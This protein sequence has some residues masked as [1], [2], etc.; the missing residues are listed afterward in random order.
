MSAPIFPHFFQHLLLSVF[1]IIAILQ[2]LKW[3]LTVVLVC[4]SLVAKDDKCFFMCLLPIRVCSLEK[5][6][7]RLFPHSSPYFFYPSCNHLKFKKYLLID[8]REMKGERKRETSIYRSTYLFTHWLICVCALTGD[9]TCKL[10]V[11]GWC[12]N[13]ATWSGQKKSHSYLPLFLTQA[14]A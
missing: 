13:Q 3:Y 10:D 5:C 11:S 12:I 14:N 2:V 9:W 6:L 8:F 7:F 1:L 4:I